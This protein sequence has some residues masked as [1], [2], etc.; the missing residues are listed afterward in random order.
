MSVGPSRTSGP[1]QPFCAT[2]PGKSA[3]C[4]GALVSSCC[5][6]FENAVRPRAR[7]HLGY[8]SE[9]PLAITWTPLKDSVAIPES[10]GVRKLME[11][12]VASKRR[13]NRRRA[14][15]LFLARLSVSD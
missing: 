6:E 4:I 15:L 8:H 10:S 13:P 11:E 9:A 5:G 14:S 1:Q 3:I 2:I 12:V 7:R